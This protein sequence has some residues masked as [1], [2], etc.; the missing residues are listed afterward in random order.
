MTRITL[1]LNQL[2]YDVEVDAERALLSVLRE[3]LDLTGTKYGCGDGKCGACTVLVDGSPVQACSVAAVDVAGKRITTV[4]GLAAGGR[5][6]AVQAAFLEMS[7]LQCGYCTPGMLMTATALLAANPDPSEAEILHALQDNIC[8]CGAHPRIVA[9]VRQA[10]AWLRGG[11][12]PDM[13]PAAAEPAA[14]AAPDSFDDGLVVAYPDPDVAA[15]AFGDDAPPPDRR[16]LTQIGPLV[17]IADDGAIRVFV[18][19]AEVGQNMRASVA[20]LVAEELR[21]APEQIQV[22]AADTGRDPYDVGTFGS[23]T[24]P[25]TG[26]QVLRAGAAMRDLLVDLAAAGWAVDGAEL[27][28]L[29]GKVVHAPSGRQASFGELARDRQ[30]TRIADPDQPV[31]PPAEWTVAGQPMRKPNGAAFVTGRHRFAAD[32]ALPAMLAG[33]VLRPPAF[34]ATLESLDTRAAEQ[35]P[36]VIVVRDGDFVGV[37]APN[38]AAAVRAGD[39]LKARWQTELQISSPELFDYLKA[40]ALERESRRDPAA[41]PADGWRGPLFPVTGDPDAATAGAVQRMAESYTVDYIAHAPLE[42]RAALAVWAGERL[43]V[44]TGSQRPFGVQA[45]L[46]AFFAIDLANVRVIVPETGAGYGGKHAGDAAIEA[47]RLARAAGRP[48]KIVWTR[49]EE[50]TWAYFRPAGLIELA[51]AVDA[52]GRLTVLEMTN[53]NSGAAGIEAR[54]AIPH[55]RITFLPADPP[56]RQGA[57]RALATTANHFARESHIDGWAHRLGEDPLAFRLRHIDDARLRAVFTAAAVTFGWESRTPAA[58][59]GFGIAGGSDKGSYVA[60]CVE[61]A[62][63]PASGAL[64]VL[65]VVEAFECGAIINPDN[66]R[67][68]VEG[69]IIQGLGGALYECVRFANGRVLNPGFDGYRVPRFMDLPRIETVLLDRRDLPSV[70]A[71][72]TPI[73]AIAPALANAIFHATGKRVR[74]MPLAPTGHVPG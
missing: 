6:D 47:A 9:A 67:A 3:D 38:E 36:G 24:T 72:E 32:M 62:V 68:Q 42:P 60:A 27:S 22:I 37:V 5:L 44:W 63:D 70:G 64:T 45:E 31:T 13:L 53:Y 74:S 17:H 33:K 2:D 35:L 41:V 46:A 12:W 15:A 69:A 23:R 58:H 18:G 55:Q 71:G 19:K 51:S 30:I 14:Q 25:I 26:P 66:V 11:T 7:A 8:R 43:T 59:H 28:V 50:F 56:L 49:Q 21:V 40:T 29:D 52:N 48:V 61:V 16:V 10:A 65:H 73:L 20:Q 57:Y 39:A 1:S 54:Y 34:R 4:E